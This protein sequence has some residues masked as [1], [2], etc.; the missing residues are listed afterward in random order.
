MDNRRR[1]GG[2]LYALKLHEIYIAVYSVKRHLI[3]SYMYNIE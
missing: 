2:R 1:R 3:I